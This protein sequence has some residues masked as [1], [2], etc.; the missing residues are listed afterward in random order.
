[1]N[2]PSERTNPDSEK[3]RKHLV[4]LDGIA[5]FL[6]VQFHALN[7][8]PL[9]PFSPIR[10]SLAY[11]GLSLFTFSAGSKL[12]LNHAG[13]LADRTF[14]GAYFLRRFDRLYRPYLGYTALI[15]LPM[16]AVCFIAWYILGLHFPG[17]STFFSAIGSL[18]PARALSFFIGNNPVT[19]HLWYLLA[20]II[21]TAVTFTTLLFLD[22][23]KVVALGVPLFL[24]GLWIFSTTVY[25]AD[26]LPVRAFLLLPFFLA[27]VWSGPRIAAGEIGKSGPVLWSTALLFAGFSFALAA[28]SDPAISGA[29]MF[30]LCLLFPFLLLG[31]A[32]IIRMTGPVCSFL[33][34]SGRNAFQIYLFHLPLI[35]L[36]LMRISTDVLRLRFFFMPFLIALLAMGLS[37][38][39]Y[40]I[41][42]KAGLGFL[43]ER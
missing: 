25:F 32:A 40:R 29:L 42:L 21:I 39:A 10:F 2:A 20:L 13:D 37:V 14:L 43:I 24:I 15:F 11:L 5:I 4:I 38:L 7:S 22:L 28:V 17:I 27:G 9:N 26:E 3:I 34:F 19:G 30:C 18:N 16:L 35:L 23:R 6:I 36:V 31:M 33:L 8:D 41:V 12:A 1:M